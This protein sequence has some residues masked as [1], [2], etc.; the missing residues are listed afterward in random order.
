MKTVTVVAATAGRV[1]VVRPPAK[2]VPP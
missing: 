1:P 2:L